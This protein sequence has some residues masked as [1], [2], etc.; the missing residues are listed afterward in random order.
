M[1][2]LVGELYM[3]NLYLAN[4]N[5]HQNQFFQQDQNIKIVRFEN[6]LFE[7]ESMVFLLDFILFLAIESETVY[8]INYKALS[9]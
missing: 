1:T 8:I 9:F 3:K 5:L 2:N 7:N 6:C 4:N